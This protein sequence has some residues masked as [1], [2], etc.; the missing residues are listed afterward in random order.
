MGG[1]SGGWDRIPWAACL[2]EAG[3]GG[4]AQVGAGG[5]VS[6]LRGGPGDG[7]RAWREASGG[8]LCGGGG[9]YTR[10][11]SASFLSGRPCGSPGLSCRPPR[12]FRHSASRD[13]HRPSRSSVQGVPPARPHAQ[14]PGGSRGQI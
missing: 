13:S 8:R 5:G 4:H 1:A 14:A 3:I 11:A 10:Q 12:A 6:V 7:A 9:R 2:P